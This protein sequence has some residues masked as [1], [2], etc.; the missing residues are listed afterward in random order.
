MPLF[1]LKYVVNEDSRSD[2]MTL[3]G[4]M[5]EEQ[6]AADTGEYVKIMGRWATVGSSSG[7]CICDDSN[8]KELNKWLLNWATMA[9]IDC[10]PVVDDNDARRIIL[11]S[12]PSYTV[13]Y[14]N[15]KNDAKDGESL[16]FIEYK[17][18]TSKRE[19]GLNIFANFSKEEDEKD[20]GEN[21]CYG[22]WHNLG[23]GSGVAICSSKSQFDLYS[24][25]FN[26]SSMCDCHIQ[27][28][29]SDNDCRENIKSKPDFQRKHT[30]LMAILFPTKV[31][32]G[33]FR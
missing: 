8:A 31:K 32:S 20:A 26:W 25:A 15:V 23:E 27:P 11:K 33:W 30:E 16:Y 10:I 9:T 22:R 4:G 6:D 1:F 3:F 29:V 19:E 24:W 2:C 18:H 13:D 12:E 7:Y 14:D 17:F 21:T 28:V 5:T